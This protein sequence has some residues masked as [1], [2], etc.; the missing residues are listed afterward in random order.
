MVVSAV[1]KISTTWLISCIFFAFLFSKSEGVLLE[2][3][4]EERIQLNFTKQKCEEYKAEIIEYINWLGSEDLDLQL[5]CSI[6]YFESR[7]NPKAISVVNAVGL[8]QVRSIVL[9][10]LKRTHN[11]DSIDL[12]DSLQ[13]LFVGIWYLDRIKHYLPERCEKTMEKRLHFVLSSYNHG[14][15]KTLKYK[16]CKTNYSNRVINRYLKKI[17]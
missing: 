13:N 7:F 10:E 6:I 11:I 3:I 17:K 16:T 8:M 9:K 14:V 1:A 12:T 2:K 15:G 5:I 4:K